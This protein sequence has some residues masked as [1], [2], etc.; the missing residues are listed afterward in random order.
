M[1]G[2]FTDITRAMMRDVSFRP[3]TTTE[4]GIRDFVAWYRDDYKFEMP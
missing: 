3:D 4:D 2:D 1:R